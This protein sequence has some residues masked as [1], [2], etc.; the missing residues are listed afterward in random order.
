MN[1]RKMLGVIIAVVIV[2]AA[3]GIALY[4]HNSE[5]AKVT[6]PYLPTID[7]TATSPTQLQTSQLDIVAQDMGA[8]GIHTN[9]VTVSSSVADGF[10]TPSAT[11]NMY[12][13][14]WFPDY[15]D[16]I[17][18]QLEVGTNVLDGGVGGNFAWVNNTTLQ[19]M[20]N[21]LDFE[22]NK[23]QQI[24]GVTQAYSILYNLSPD[25][26]LPTPETYLF[27]QPYVNNVTYN[28]YIE[29]FYNMMSYANHSV[30][31]LSP[32]NTTYLTDVSPSPGPD[33]LDPA[34][35]FFEVDTP[36]YSQIYQ[37]LVGYNGSSSSYVPV[38][39]SS[40]T[41]Q[42]YQNY[43]F[44][45]RPYLKFS[46]GE[47]LNGTDVWFSFYRTILMGQGPGVANYLDILFNQT[48]YISTG[49]ALPVG[50]QQA[51]EAGGYTFSGTAKQNVTQEVN[52]LQNI[53]SNFNTNSSN[54]KIMEYPGQTVSI[55]VNN[56]NIV[57]IS[58]VRPYRFFLEDLCGMG[59]GT[60]I[61]PAYVDAHGGVIA[62]QPNTYINLHGAIG[63][64]PYVFYSIGSSLSTITLQK[65]SNYWALGHSVPAVIQPAHIKYIIIDFALSHADRVS[66]FLNN[67]AQIS[68]VSAPFIKDIAGASPYNGIP[69]NSYFRNFGTVEPQTAYISLNTEKAPTNNTY[70]RE[71][72]VR[73][74]NYSALET[75]YVYKNLTLATLELG[76]ITNNFPGYYDPQGLMY[77]YNITQAEHFMS[78]AGMFGDF[79]VTLPNGTV[80]GNP[81]VSNSPS[82]SLTHAI[83]N[84]I[85][86]ELN[87]AWVRI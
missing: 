60:V 39:A 62:N 31:G 11:P 35:G 1:F 75:P 77:T 29:Y 10:T 71:A 24:N 50:L 51:L 58:T 67:Q 3:I 42:N 74:I 19:Q 34:T 80:L 83:A 46:N 61:Y 64:G 63:S 32:T 40:V 69:F 87:I 37:G 21:Y 28:G 81:R 65:N 22:V 23:T 44:N 85:S 76:P 82:I 45:L 59:W 57:N 6:S 16:P 20:Y 33:N 4:L 26:W 86:E 36:V 72:I 48:Q 14:G 7:I 54:M 66:E 53:L 12:L 84:M 55:G 70:L 68:F 47:P 8:I 41:E 73:A 56:Q 18:Q 43:S 49:Y 52:I 38:L 25:I 13:S 17:G 30:D 27:V 9:I 15:P 5:K 78:L 79:H 2:V